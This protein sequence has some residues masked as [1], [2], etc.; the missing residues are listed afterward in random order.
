[1]AVVLVTLAASAVAAAGLWNMC[2]PFSVIS[3]WLPPAIGAVILITGLG[4]QRLRTA[5]DS[6]T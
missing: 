5:E 1:M 2:R 3:D 6:R 4:A